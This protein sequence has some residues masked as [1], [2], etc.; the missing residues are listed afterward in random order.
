MSEQTVSERLFESHCTRNGFQL[1]R[2]EVEQGKTPDYEM[3]LSGILVAV[4]VKEI[5]P[6]DANKE[7]WRQFSESGS[8]SFYCNSDARLRE[9]IRMGCKQLKRRT[10]E[11]RPAILIVYDNNTLRWH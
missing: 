3:A 10:Q 4:E 1:Q 8:A 6:N 2:V 9:K 7:V 11:S 5:S